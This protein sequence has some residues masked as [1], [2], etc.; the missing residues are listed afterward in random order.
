MSNRF[1]LKTY[2]LL[3]CFNKEKKHQLKI[4]LNNK[5][6]FEKSFVENKIEYVKISDYFNFK[7][8]RKCKLIIQWDGEESADKFLL[9][10]R[11][12]INQQEIAPYSF[13]YFPKENF[14]I[15]NLN[16]I[17]KKELVKKIIKNGQNYGW[18]GKLIC[19]FLLG[20]KQE[21]EKLKINDPHS[22]N[23][24]QPHEIYTEVENQLFNKSLKEKK[25]H[26]I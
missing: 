7:E 9:L 21:I 20:N 26:D 23:S 22:L 16:D 11:L 4:F 14:Y 2:I 13:L 25:H 6:I 3:S 12:A 8:F 17:E 19:N 5:K 24:L 15:K 10:Q 18:Y 1:N